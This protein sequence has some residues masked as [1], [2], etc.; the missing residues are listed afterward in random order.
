MTMSAHAHH[1]EKDR[2]SRSPDAAGMAFP[3]PGEGR[4]VM[5]RT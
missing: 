2:A 3:G 1:Q 4:N 5:Q